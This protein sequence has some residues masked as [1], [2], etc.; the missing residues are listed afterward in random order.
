MSKRIDWDRTLAKLKS[1]YHRKKRVPSFSEIQSLLGYRSKGGVARLVGHLVKRG[2]LRKDSRGRLIPTP[3]LSGGIK[4]L[5][6]IQAGFPSPAEEEL[7]DTL[8]LDE[9]LIRKPESTYLVKVTGDSMIEAGIHPGDLILVERGRDP[10]SGNIVVAQ[11]DGEWTLKFFEKRNGQV[12]L[13]AGNRKY[14]PIRPSR[15]LTVGGVVV[16]NVRKYS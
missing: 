3:V 14:P 12:L 9:F 13:R 10:K 7:V 8:S 6:T 15:E 2:I 16:A 1:F 11:V 5:G 4:L